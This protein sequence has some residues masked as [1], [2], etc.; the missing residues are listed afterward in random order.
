MS[1]WSV[2]FRNVSS[3]RS[4]SNTSF[5]FSSSSV[6]ELAFTRN[7]TIRTIWLVI[8]LKPLFLPERDHRIDLAGP[9]CRQPAGEARNQKQDRGHTNEDRKVKHSVPEMYIYH[10][11]DQPANQGANTNNT[12]SFAH[13]LSNNAPGRC[14][15]SEPHRNFGCSLRHRT[16]HHGVDA[17]SRQRQQ[18]RTEHGK[19]P[20][21]NAA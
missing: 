1:R 5:S 3:S 20:R 19:H 15:E 16:G 2:A 12:H 8:S 18:Q 6:L 17:D 7:R 14:A 10:H 11:C 4:T 13:D 21:R 9:I